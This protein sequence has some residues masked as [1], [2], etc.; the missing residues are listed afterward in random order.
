MGELAVTYW[1]SGKRELTLPLFEETL[2]LQKAKVG[3]DHPNTL[4]SMHNLA[5]AYSDLDKPDLAIPLFVETVELMK[6]KL[7][8]DHPQTLSTMNNLAEAYLKARKPDLAVP[9][10]EET[11]RRRKARL[12]PEH[13]DTLT[14]MHNLAAA[15]REV[16]KIDLA[17]PLLQQTLKHRKAK[18]GP[19]QL[20]TLKTMQYLAAAYWSVTKLE[21]SIPLFEETLQRLDTKLGW[22]HLETLRNDS[23]LGVNYMDAGRLKEANPLLEEAYQASKQ[24]SPIRWVGRSLLEAYTKAGEN[25][26]FANLQQELLAEARKT[27]PKDSPELARLLAQIGR[28]LLTL[29]QW[30]EAEPPLR[31]SLAIPEQKE[32]DDWR[33]FD[34]QSLLGGALLGQ[35]KYGAAEPLLLKGYEGLKQREKTIPPPGSTLIPAALDRLIALYTATNNPDEAMK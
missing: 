18:L 11:L 24:R 5:T 25:T 34:T 27:L 8:P 4:T 14:S 12:G 21:K 16:G 1:L 19:S 32:S 13:P 15:Y 22:N 28:G 7:G 31:E 30:T 2:K 35:K 3:S 23:N 33:T 29:K 9:L 26:K 17:L 6:A 10:I 20:D